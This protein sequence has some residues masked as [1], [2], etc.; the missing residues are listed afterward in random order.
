MCD[1]LKV[2]GPLIN[3][4]MFRE[5]LQGSFSASSNDFSTFFGPG[6]LLTFTQGDFSSFALFI[7]TFYAMLESKMER[8]F[9]VKFYL[10]RRDM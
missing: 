1:Y 9:T 5:C 10:Q 3:T 2:T 4:A 7:T 6:F 8:R